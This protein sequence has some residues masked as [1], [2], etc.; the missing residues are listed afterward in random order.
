MGSISRDEL[1]RR[2]DQVL[3]DLRRTGEPVVVDEGDNAVV[4]MPL[5]TFESWQE[6]AHLLGTPAN[7]DRLRA[8]IRDAEAGRLEEH[9][10]IP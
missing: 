9:D 7:A 3:D 5:S 10:V 6:T 4:V 2:L 1:R 8:A